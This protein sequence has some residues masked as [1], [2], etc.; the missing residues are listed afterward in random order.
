[1]A[2]SRQVE[3]HYSYSHKNAIIL[4]TIDKMSLKCQEKETYKKK[5]KEIQKQYPKRIDLMINIESP[6]LNCA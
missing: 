1:M 4:S 5:E 2:F 6:W 3:N